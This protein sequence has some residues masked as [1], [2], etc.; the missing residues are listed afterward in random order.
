MIDFWLG[1]G[2]VIG[3]AGDGDP[4]ADSDRDPDTVSN[5]ER[6]SGTSC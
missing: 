1:I 3:F 5:A 4:A 6:Q 2:I